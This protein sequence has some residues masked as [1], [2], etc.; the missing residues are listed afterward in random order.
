MTY[1]QNL[2]LFWLLLV[3]II[4]VPGL[5][6]L[7]V[8]THSLSRGLKAGLSAVAGIMTAGAVHTA[9][10]AVGVALLLTFPDGAVTPLLIAGSAYLGWIGFTLV[11]SSI[12]VDAIGSDESGGGL[13]AFRQGALTAILNP[14]AYVFVLSVYPQVLRAEF[15]PLLPQAMV[16]GVMT[17]ATQLAIYGGMALAAGRVRRWLLASPWATI[18]TGRMAGGIFLVFAALTLWQAMAN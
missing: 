1:T 11:R 6:M 3:G 9:W 12:T 4:A 5:D 10:G 7:L 16:A 15:G 8:L 13:V 17:A 2:F 14:K 18:L